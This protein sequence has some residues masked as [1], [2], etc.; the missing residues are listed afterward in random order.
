MMGDLIRSFIHLPT[1]RKRVIKEFIINA[2]NQADAN[3]STIYIKGLQNAIY[4]FFVIQFYVL[5]A[6][7]CYT[8]RRM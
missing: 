6:S 4:F 2:G 1:S 7:L 8:I 3:S 5:R